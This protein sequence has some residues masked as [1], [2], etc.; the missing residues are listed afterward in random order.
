MKIRICSDDNEF[1]PHK[2]SSYKVLST[3]YLQICTLEGASSVMQNVCYNFLWNVTKMMSV[4]L[5]RNYSTFFKHHIKYFVRKFQ[6][7]RIGWYIVNAEISNYW[8]DKNN[9]IPWEITI[10]MCAVFSKKMAGL[11]VP[12]WSI[13]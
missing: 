10:F 4:T 5:V 13:S 9:T 7:R 12:G 8:L 11:A 3:D 2:D 1:P 6:Q